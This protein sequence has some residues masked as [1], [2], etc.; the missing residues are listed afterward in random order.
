MKMY[1]WQGGVHVEPENREDRDA[2]M[3]LWNA[4]K[5][6]SGASQ[7]GD[8]SGSLSVIGEKLLNIGVGE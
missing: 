7:Q 1:W 6:T 2:L 4:D 5:V 8:G 3:R